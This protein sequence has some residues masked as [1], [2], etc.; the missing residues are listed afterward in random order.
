M[1]TGA[2]DPGGAQ[3]PPLPQGIVTPARAARRARTLS[4]FGILFS[5]LD[6]LVGIA[7]GSGGSR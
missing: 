1:P 5:D 4:F 7:C 3:T 2:R 6:I